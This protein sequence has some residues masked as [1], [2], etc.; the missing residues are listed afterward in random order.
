MIGL[1]SDKKLIFPI[2]IPGTLSKF[3]NSYK[4]G[5]ITS[6]GE[7]AHPEFFS[8]FQMMGKLKMKQRC[9]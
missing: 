5:V 1:G 3:Y 9:G 8:Y 7:G 4:F 6:K 2:R